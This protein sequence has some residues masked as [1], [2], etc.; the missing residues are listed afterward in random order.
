MF[1]VFATNLWESVFC[2]TEM[3]IDSLYTLGGTATDL[4]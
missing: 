2:G 1:Y 3:V 4:L